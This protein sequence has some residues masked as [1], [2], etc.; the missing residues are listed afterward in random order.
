MAPDLRPVATRRDEKGPAREAGPRREEMVGARGFEP[1]TPRSRTV[2]AT[3]LRYAPTRARRRKIASAGRRR[4][5]QG[6]RSA[7]SS[8]SRPRPVAAR[9]GNA[10]ERAVRLEGDRVDDAESCPPRSRTACP[11]RAERLED[12]VGEARPVSTLDAVRQ[13]L[14]V[15]ARRGD[16]LAERLP[17]R[18][19]VQEDLQDGRRNRRARPASRA[20]S[21]AGRPRGRSSASSTRA[22]AR[23]GARRSPRPARGRTGSASPARP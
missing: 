21:A 22:A 13:V 2:C 11:R 1:P 15:E 10:G 8:R 23:R 9:V 19:G 6:C 4:H 14:V 7:T 12:V 3:R 20:R 18:A 17:A 16:G 5:W